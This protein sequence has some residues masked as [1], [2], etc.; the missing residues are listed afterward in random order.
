MRYRRELLERLPADTPGW[1]IRASELRIFFFKF[2]QLAVKL[3]VLAVSNGGRRFL[4]IATIVL[5]DVAPQRFDPRTRFR[6]GHVLIIRMRIRETM[7][8]S[9]RVRHPEPRRQR[10]SGS[11]GGTS[12]KVAKDA[13]V[14]CVISSTSLGMTVAPVCD[15]R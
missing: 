10:Q 11:D 4:I 6:F 7:A 2:G 1:R 9:L 12:H 13:N 14:L 8:L 3:I 5:S 15:R